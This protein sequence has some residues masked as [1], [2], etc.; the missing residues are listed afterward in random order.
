MANRNV[1][2]VEHEF[3]F[4]PTYVIEAH[5]ETALVTLSPHIPWEIRQQLAQLLADK[6]NELNPTLITDKQ[7]ETLRD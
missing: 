3:D 4:E 6:L 2:L 1:Y 7:L 5:E